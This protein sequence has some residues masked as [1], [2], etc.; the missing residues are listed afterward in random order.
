MTSLPPD[1]SRKEY[2][3]DQLS[4]LL[5]PPQGIGQNLNPTHRKKNTT[6]FVRM[7]KDVT[8]RPADQLVSFDVTSLFTQVPL[9]DALMMVSQKL[10]EDQTLQ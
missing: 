6:E 4:P 8:I 10:T 9:D 3:C 7:L 5:D 2:I 1:V